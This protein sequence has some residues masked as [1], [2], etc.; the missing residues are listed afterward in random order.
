MRAESELELDL[1]TGIAKAEFELDFKR[2]RASTPIYQ[3][4]IA[5]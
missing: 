4:E 2:E 5:T 3:R 1:E